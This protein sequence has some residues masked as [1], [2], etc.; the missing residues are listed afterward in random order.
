[1]VNSR[2]SVPIHPLASTPFTVYVAFATGTNGVLSITPLS[3]AY[4]IAPLAEKITESPSQI[5]ASAPALT[6]G[7][8]LTVIVALVGVLG[9]FG[10]LASTATTV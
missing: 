8:G 6:S 1:M 2:A 5:V 9:Q 10:V 4:W 3:Q 7:K